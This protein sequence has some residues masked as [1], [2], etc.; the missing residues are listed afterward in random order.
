MHSA[1]VDVALQTSTG[2]QVSFPVPVVWQGGDWKVQLTDDGTP[3][4]RPAILQSLAG[5]VPWAG[6]E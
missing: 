6:T 5:Y 2:E 1:T 4:F 3:V